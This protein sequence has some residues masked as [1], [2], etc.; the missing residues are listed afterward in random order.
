MNKNLKVQDMHTHARASTDSS[1]RQMCVSELA[2]G[3]HLCAASDNDA[4]KYAACQRETHVAG[5][6]LLAL[7]AAVSVSGC[8]ATLQEAILS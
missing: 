1:D 8:D 7:V 2:D 4:A 3:G 6:T 5:S